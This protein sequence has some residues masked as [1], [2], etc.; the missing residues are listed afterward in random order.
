M[1]PEN[2]N[3]IFP[4]LS[5]QQL[6]TWIYK[7]IRLML[8]QH[9]YQ[10]LNLGLTMQ[11]F[12]CYGPCLIYLW[13]FSFGNSFTVPPQTKPNQKKSVLV[14]YNL[15]PQRKIIQVDHL[16][17]S[18]HL[19]FSKYSPQRWRLVI[20]KDVQSLR[21]KQVLKKWNKPRTSQKGNYSLRCVSG[22]M[23]LQKINTSYDCTHAFQ[24][25]LSETDY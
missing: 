2:R 20:I 1:L 21:G 12:Q 15:M 16:L 18:Q 6:T 10:N 9:A 7:M 19:A 17:D 25:H 8:N 3:L 24:S 11:F 5:V 14:L 22:D 23:L 4:N 13:Y